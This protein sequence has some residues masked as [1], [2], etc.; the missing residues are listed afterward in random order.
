[1][2]TLDIDIE[3]AKGIFETNFWGPL[4]CVKAFAPL[5]VQA[6]GVV[7]NNC[8]ISSKV[9]VPWIGELSVLYQRFETPTL[10]HDAMSLM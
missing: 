8:S 7:V 2:P 5:V 4:A 6:K 1:M 3:A 10:F 9:N